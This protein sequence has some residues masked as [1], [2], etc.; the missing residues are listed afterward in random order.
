[1]TWLCQLVPV[2]DK[3]EAQLSEP[4]RGCCSTHVAWF[5]K[6]NGP[7]TAGAVCG[8]KAV[9][10]RPRAA[11]CPT[12]RWSGSQIRANTTTQITSADQKTFS[13]MGSSCLGRDSA[14]SELHLELGRVCGTYR[15]GH[16]VAF[17]ADMEGLVETA[18]K[19]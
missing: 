16:G 4:I 15:R 18:Q 14:V 17:Q 2:H 5:M 1:M 3:A 9:V 6:G 7:C 13:A 10:Q 12:Q 19:K 8:V 11:G